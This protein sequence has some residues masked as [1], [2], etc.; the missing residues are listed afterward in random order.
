MV[1][2][3]PGPML[4]SG[5]PASTLHARRFADDGTPMG[6]AVALSDAPDEGRQGLGTWGGLAAD[7]D[8][9]Y[10]VAWTDLE[11]AD[12]DTGGKARGFSA[13]GTPAGDTVL[14][15]S[16]FGDAVAALP[17]GG[18]VTMG[19]VL[20]EGTQQTA[21][22]IFGPDGAPVGPTFRSGASRRAHANPLDGSRNAI[23]VGTEGS[24]QQLPLSAAHDGCLAL[25]WLEE[26]MT[27][28]MIGDASIPIA[29]GDVLGLL[30]GGS[31][32]R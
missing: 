21:L 26:V 19:S 17:D 8:G 28:D 1:S 18:F 20:E 30:L 27:S 31:T 5:L 22:R 14:I 4:E 10:L 16:S 32:A 24:S 15:G 29:E 13:D 6:D 3:I 7:A 11:N 25:A 9:G 23:S 2:A 12:G